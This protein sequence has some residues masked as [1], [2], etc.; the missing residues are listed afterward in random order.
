[1]KIG[2]YGGTFDPV[3]Y[4][5]LLLAERCREAL[6]LDEVRF[7]PAGDP[8]HK[9]RNDLTPGTARAEMLEFATAGHPQ[10]TVDR[11]ELQRP[12]PHYTFETLGEVRRDLPDAEL[13]F[14]M[15]ADS[16]ADLPRWRE[17]GRIAQLAT[18]VAVNRG[19]RP[20]PE[21]SSLES[22]LGEAIASRVVFVTMP[23]IDLSSTELRERAAA[24]KSLRY[25]MPAAVEAYI[26]DKMLYRAK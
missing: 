7:V 25:T 4:G 21:R 14:L 10:L 6:G 9:D 5:H 12:G 24:G 15:G 26:R 20:L 17:P 3:H 13:F 18:I 22:T 2:L 11:R 19:D 23:G 8:P 1:M 16:L